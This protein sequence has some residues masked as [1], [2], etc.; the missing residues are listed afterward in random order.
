MTAFSYHTTH[1]PSCNGIGRVTGTFGGGEY[2]CDECDG[3]GWVC[4]ECSGCGEESP[5]NMAGLCE[6]CA[7]VEVE[8][9]GPGR[10]AA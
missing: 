7:L 10:I 1:C 4:R 9:L 3:L 8:H 2:R 5:L 6:E